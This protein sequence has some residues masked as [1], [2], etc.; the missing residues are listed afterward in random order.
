[1]GPHRSAQTLA[2]ALVIVILHWLLAFIAFYSDAFGTLLK[3]AEKIL[4]RDGR[5]QWSAM[6][7]AN[8]TTPPDLPVPSLSQSSSRPS[9]SSLDSHPF[10]SADQV[11][12]ALALNR[13]LK[14]SSAAFGAPMRSP[15]E[16]RTDLAQASRGA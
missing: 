14:H 7:G 1:M 8:I 2:G 13:R 6:R 10:H 15:A 3:G 5:L 4:I 12:T 9:G 11:G 16:Y